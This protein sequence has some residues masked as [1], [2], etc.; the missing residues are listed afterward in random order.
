MRAE[1]A[2]ECGER[3]ERSRVQRLEDWQLQLWRHIQV[4]TQ[5]SE[6]KLEEEATPKE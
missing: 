1:K 2:R 3:Q 5:R 4:P 6:Q